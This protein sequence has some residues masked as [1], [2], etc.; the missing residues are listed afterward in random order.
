MHYA[1]TACDLVVGVTFRPSVY[2]N[3]AIECYDER[4][5]PFE[6]FQFYECFSDAHVN[7]KR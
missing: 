1:I 3:T 4:D 6:R 2:W 5:A 7:N